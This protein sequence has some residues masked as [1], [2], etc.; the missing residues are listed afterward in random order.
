MRPID[1]YSRSG[2]NACVTTLEQPTVDTADVAAAMFSHLCV[3]LSAAKKPSWIKGRA[4]DLTAAYR[5]LCVAVRSRR[6]AVIAVYNPHTKKTMLFT[7]VCLPFGSRASVNGFIRCSRCIQWLANRCLIV[8]TT[9]YYDDFIVASPDC[10]ADNTGTTMELLFQLLGWV[11]DTV[12]PKADVFSRQVS[13]LGIRFDLESSGGCTIAVD[14]TEKRKSDIKALVSGILDKGVLPHRE[15]LELRG[16]LSFANSQVMGKAGHYALKHISSHVHAWP[17]VSKLDAPAREALSFLLER[18]L[19]GVPRRITKSLGQPWLVFTDASFEPNFTGG[20]G[21]VLISP[22]G[23]VVSWFSLPLCADDIRPLL[24]MAA[25][26]GIGE[27]ETVAVVLAFMLWEHKLSSTECVAYLDNE[28][29]RFALVKGYSASWAIT[30]ICHI[31]ATTC[32]QHTV[33]PWCARVPS[34]SNIADH[35]SRNKECDLLPQCLAHDAA[36][37]SVFFNDIVQSVITLS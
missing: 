6:F 28:G 1:D 18:I 25:D 31:F 23:S 10:L 22:F 27:L 30:R 24:P 15:G 36:S 33:L 9:S 5:Q 21:G 35:P 20:L 2:V 7:Q 32:E 13:A 29:A 3:K 4:F 12:G 8:P 26:T 37:V 14:N 34:C 17:F 11:F 16:K 19:R